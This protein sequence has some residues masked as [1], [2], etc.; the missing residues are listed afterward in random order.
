MTF[1]GLNSGHQEELET[2]M[3]PITEDDDAQ[4]HAPSVK[5]KRPLQRSE[6]TAY[7]SCLF[8]CSLLTN[9]FFPAYAFYGR[10]SMQDDQPQTHVPDGSSDVDFEDEADWHDEPNVEELAPRHRSKFSSQQAR[11]IEVRRISSHPFPTPSLRLVFQTPVWQVPATSPGLS[12]S[13]GMHLVS[14]T[15]V[16]MSQPTNGSTTSQAS[17]APSQ[18]AS[19]DCVSS[20][21]GSRSGQPLS[22]GGSGDPSQPIGKGVPRRRGR[23]AA[24][25]MPQPISH[26]WP[27]DTDLVFQEGTNKLMIMA[28]QPLVRVV[29]QD[30]VEHFQAS[31]LSDH[32]FPDY[33]AA[34][35][36]A[37]GALLRSAKSH[38][39]RALDIHSRLQSDGNYLE[40]ISR[41]VCYSQPEDN[42]TDMSD[43]YAFGSHISGATPKTSVAP[44]SH[45]SFLPLVL[46]IRLQLL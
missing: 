11:D 10:S 42:I 17:G 33:K 46:Q 39:P 8:V 20:T 38:F 27:A 32:T 44:S 3:D 13:E 37:L 7:Q 43:R 34:H 24:I 6:S 29:L 41:L 15:G 22:S 21:Q 45:P 30:A 4:E 18:Q 36:A 5:G 16:A 2:D 23:G 12:T 31:L 9:A 25:S 40:P 26:V 28:Q 14:Q 19:Q 35:A 1:E